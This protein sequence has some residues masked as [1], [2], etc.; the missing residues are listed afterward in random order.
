MRDAGFKY[1][2]VDYNTVRRGMVSDKSLPGL[3]ERQYVDQY[4]YGISTLYTGLAPQLADAS[5]PANIGLGKQ[6]VRIFNN[7]S[8]ADQIAYNRSLFGKNTDATFAVALETEDFSRIGGCTRA[9]IEQ[10][11]HP[12]QLQATYR[13]PLDA[14]I[15]N[16]PRMIAALTQ[17]ANCMH[18]AGFKYNHPIEIEA[19]IKNRLYAITN[20]APPAALSADAKTA[21]IQLQGEERAVAAAHYNCEDNILTPVEE[22]IERELYAAPIQ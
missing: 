19:D 4:G 11:F 2:A 7:L 14:L 5:T 22:Q 18:T 3:S 1:I 15:E 9:A 16:D 17:F 20:G 6:N 8:P 10:V 21:L 12:E 13:N